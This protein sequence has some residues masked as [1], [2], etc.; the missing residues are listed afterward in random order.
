M[1]FVMS[2]TPHLTLAAQLF[3]RR[4]GGVVEQQMTEGLK[5]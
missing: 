4:V 2:A 5:N 1:E 3:C